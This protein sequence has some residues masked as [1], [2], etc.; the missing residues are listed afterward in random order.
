MDVCECMDGNARYTQ[1]E[2][3]ELGTDEHCAE[4]SMDRCRECGRIWL[5]YYLAFEAFTGSGRWYRG[6]V[7]PD[8]AFSARN[9]AAVLAKLK[10]YWA[11]GSRFGG[12]VEWRS[13]PIDTSP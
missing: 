5:H 2:R 12:K 11:G 6:E 10:G 13:G 4:I 7:G 8:M 9:A 1:F 3:S